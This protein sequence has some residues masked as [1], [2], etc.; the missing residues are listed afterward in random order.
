MSE[1]QA[2][3]ETQARLSGS[4]TALSPELLFDI[5]GSQ[6]RRFVLSNLSNESTPIPIDD[7]AYRLAAWEAGTTVA[8]VSTEIA[9]DIEILLYH[10][11]LP[12]MADSDLVTYDSGD[13]VVSPGNGIESAT[14]C[15][16]LAE[17]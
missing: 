9:E 3:L 13:G 12:K 1:R 14:D 7:L 17:F 6:H 8:D 2:K 5:L 11:H 16:E 4:D 10:V 15:L